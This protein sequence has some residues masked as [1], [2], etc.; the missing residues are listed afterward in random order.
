MQGFCFK[1]STTN[2][3]IPCKGWCYHPK[4]LTNL[5]GMGKNYI[6]AVTKFAN[7][8][9]KDISNINEK[10]ILMKLLSFAIQKGEIKQYITCTKIY[11]ANL[12]GKKEVANQVKNKKVSRIAQKLIDKGYLESVKLTHIKIDGKTLTTSK[13]IFG[14]KSM[15]ILEKMVAE[16][17][18]P[19]K[20]I[21]KETIPLFV[22]ATPPKAV[23]K[24]NDN[25]NN[26][27]SITERRKLMYKEIL[28][29]E[30]N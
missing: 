3:I 16:K 26:E 1:L 6:N 28:K 11:L 5:E 13:W 21:K 8:K 18:P 27:L 25:E 2:Y 24:T 23:A 30:G 15:E 17:A 9:L 14:A 12:I 7:E 22:A 19:K 4:H 20:I 10:I 29:N